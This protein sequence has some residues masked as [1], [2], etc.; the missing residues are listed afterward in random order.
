MTTL[1]LFHRYVFERMELEEEKSF[2]AQVFIPYPSV[3]EGILL[4]FA[5]NKV[6]PVEGK[7]SEHVI[8]QPWFYADWQKRPNYHGHVTHAGRNT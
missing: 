2:V 5:E 3:F 6:I 8:D 7:L 1:F 4:A